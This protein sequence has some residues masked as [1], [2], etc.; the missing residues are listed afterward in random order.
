[1]TAARQ[2][3]QAKLDRASKRVV[4]LQ[5]QQALMEMRRQTKELAKARQEQI[6]RR[7]ELEAAVAEAGLADWSKAELAGLLMRARDQFG[8]SQANRRILAQWADEHTIR[9]SNTLH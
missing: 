4:Q 1:M 8:D 5:A 6:R 2:H 9:G 7:L 3:L